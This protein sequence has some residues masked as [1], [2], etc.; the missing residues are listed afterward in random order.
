MPFSYFDW[1]V[2]KF[3]MLWACLSISHNQ[4]PFYFIWREK[5]SFDTPLD[6]LCDIRRTAGPEVL[7]P[8][9]NFEALW[10][11]C[12][13]FIVSFGRFDPLERRGVKV[14]ILTPFERQTLPFDDDNRSRVGA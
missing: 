12:S 13:V 11:G 6:N 5:F 14:Y 1:F 2:L 3:Q 7:L 9:S 8:I 10:A 4:M